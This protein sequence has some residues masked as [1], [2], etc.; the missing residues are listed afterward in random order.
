MRSIFYRFGFAFV[1]RAVEGRTVRRPTAAKRIAVFGALL[2]AFMACDENATTSTPGDGGAEDAVVSDAGPAFHFPSDRTAMS[3]QFDAQ[4]LGVVPLLT[5]THEAKVGNVAGLRGAYTDRDRD[6]VFLLDAQ[7]RVHRWKPLESVAGLA[8]DLGVSSGTVID[9]AIDEAGDLFTLTHFASGLEVHRLEAEGDGFAFD[10]RL[11]VMR[12]GSDAGALEFDAQGLLLI[13]IADT[14]GDPLATGESQNPQ[15]REGGISRIDVSSLD[16]TGMYAIPDDNP[17]YSEVTETYA[18]GTRSPFACD[19][20]TN[21]EVWCADRGTRVDE[22]HRIDRFSNLGWPV[23]DGRECG[24]SPSCDLQLDLFPQHV[25]QRE[26]DRCGMTPGAFW[27]GNAGSQ[28]DDTYVYVD[29]CSSKVYAM[30]TTSPDRIYWS[31]V[32]AEAPAN[33]V[34]VVRDPDGVPLLLS[35]DGNVY[36]VALKYTAPFP[37]RLSETGCFEALLELRAEAGVVPY[38]VNA[39]LWTDG[40][41]K[42]RHFELPPGKTLAA[43]STQWSFPV[44]SVVLKTFSYRLSAG[45]ALTPV[46]TRVMLKRPYGWEFHSYAWLE[47]GSDALLLDKGDERSLTGYISEEARSIKHTFPSRNACITCHGREDDLTIGFR[48]DQLDRDYAYALRSEN[49]IVA[50]LGAGLISAAPNVVEAMPD[51]YDETA[52]LDS[53]ARSYLHTNCAHCHRPGGWV[54]ANLKMDLRYDT[55][56]ADADA[57][58]VRTSFGITEQYRIS[59]GDP[60]DSRIAAR[61]NQRGFDQMPP[62][63][64][65]IVDEPGVAL[66]REWISALKSCPEW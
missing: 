53:R 17:R 41:H 10:S 43:Q 2:C 8:V 45:A 42:Q 9:L 66:I 5:V 35:E 12:A 38:D 27:H 26:G 65:S 48:T 44:G 30:L 4:P 47:D 24:Q 40:A 25:L 29:T 62:L 14:T 32:S 52:S 46:E 18:T 6:V 58:G 37:R 54:P 33:I 11:L 39:P 50:L 51:P 21:G 28:T 7:N 36:R 19:R 22:L 61:M 15:S 63:A 55:P 20:R 1:A 56:L 23:Y 64:T 13:A 3:C 34:T 57:C 31:G 16:E 59:P 49:Q 60:D